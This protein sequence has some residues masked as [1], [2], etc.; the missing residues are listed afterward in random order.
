MHPLIESL[1]WRYAT[2]KFDAKKKISNDNLAIIKEA[3]RLAP[4]SYGMQ[5]YQVLIVENPELRAQLQPASWGQTQIVDASH[6]LVFSSYTNVTEKMVDDYVALKAGTEEVAVD[7]LKP[8]GD[9][10]KSK[11]LEASPV[12]IAVWAAKQTYIALDS[13]MIACADL[14]IDAC[15][16]EGFE[17]DAYNKILGLTEKG[18]TASVVATIG[19]RA[20]DDLA[21][22]GK[23]VRKPAQDLFLTV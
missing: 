23:K 2:K 20:A 6:L 14:R 22:H 8:Y 9:F 16:M 3:I 17:A 10:M 4:S 11:L 21:Q 1:N 7:Q 19:Y 18:M 13:L 12:E 15:P 5:P